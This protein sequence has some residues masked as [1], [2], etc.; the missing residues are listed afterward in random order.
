MRLITAFKLVERRHV[1]LQERKGAKDAVKAVGLEE[2]LNFIYLGDTANIYFILIV[3]GCVKVCRKDRIAPYFAPV[4]TYFVVVT[5]IVFTT[6]VG[7]L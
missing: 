7:V 3:D 2:M 6:R 1:I 4:C 5:E